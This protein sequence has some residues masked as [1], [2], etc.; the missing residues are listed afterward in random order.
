MGD[1]AYDCK[2][3][4]EQ[5]DNELERLSENNETLYRV[6][7]K[8]FGFPSQ[9]QTWE[10]LETIHSRLYKN[11]TE[12]YHYKGAGPLNNDERY[13]FIEDR[14]ND[15]KT[16]NDSFLA[17][18]EIR[19]RLSWKSTAQIEEEECE[20]RHVYILQALKTL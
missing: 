18:G 8:P 4:A 11:L 17:M 7:C 16:L 1:Q 3:V 15:L 19:Q 5:I 14:L 12:V 20:R 13:E 10:A 2:A 6:L 9:P